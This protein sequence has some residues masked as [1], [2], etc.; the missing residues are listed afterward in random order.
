MTDLIYNSRSHTDKPLS[1]A[2]L[3][4]AV[5]AA[6]TTGQA[7][8]LSSRY[9]HVT[10]ETAIDALADYGFHPVQAAQKAS[11]KSDPRHSEHMLAFTNTD[12]VSC[13]DGHRSELILYNSHDGSSSLKLFAG[14]YR[15]I[16]SNGIVAGDGFEARLRH[17]QTTPTGFEEM[18]INTVNRLPDLMTRIDAMKQQTLSENA[19]LEFAINASKLRWDWIGTETN[20]SGAYGFDGTMWDLIKPKRPEDND[21]SVWSVFNR[22]QE[23]LVRGGPRVVSYTNKNPNGKSRKSRAIGSIRASVDINR[24]LWDLVDGVKTLESEV[25]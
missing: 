5:P 4:E 10:T 9:G 19:T 24:R 14:A 15:F 11:R 20:R 23:S 22:V 13:G 6:Y 12:A 2:A 18:L 7:E 8:H 3:L 1:R 21:Q 16:C 17:T 25:V